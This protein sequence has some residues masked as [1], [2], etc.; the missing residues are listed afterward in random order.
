MQQNMEQSQL[1][2]KRTDE[3]TRGHCDNTGLIQTS[4]PECNAVHSAM[5]NCKNSD[6]QNITQNALFLTVY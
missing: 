2:N 4:H 6:F 3:E 5:Q 1:Y